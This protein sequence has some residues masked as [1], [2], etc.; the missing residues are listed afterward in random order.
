MV[1]E[2][3]ARMHELEGRVAKDSHSSCKP[4]PTMNW[5]TTRQL[6]LFSQ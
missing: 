5:R 3:L 1:A 6:T 4:L 2:L